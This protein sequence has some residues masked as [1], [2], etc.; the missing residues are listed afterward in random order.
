MP[1]GMGGTAH[2]AHVGG[3]VFGLS[4]ALV[5]RFT[6]LEKRLDALVEKSVTVYDIDDEAKGQARARASRAP[7]REAGQ[8]MERLEAAA[9]AAPHDIPTHEQLLRAAREM[10]DG[11]REARTTAK[12]AD[13]YL[14]YGRVE[15][16]VALF[17]EA[18]ATG[19]DALV[20]RAARMQIA[21]HLAERG[22][23]ERAAFVYEGVLA[24]G[25][26]DAA[27]VRA[28]VEVARFAQSRGQAQRAAS[29]L[30][31]A[32]A[33]PDASPELVAEIDSLSASSP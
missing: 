14:L 23:A 29:L 8:A 3:F 15:S 31:V 12:L 33:S 32:R 20:P 1:A 22:D 27:S 5:L 16:A 30:A 24:G 28:A 10:G 6:G 26:V 11:R 18:H 2:W 7:T 21:T 17:F 13:L 25:F 4:F 9:A 19:N